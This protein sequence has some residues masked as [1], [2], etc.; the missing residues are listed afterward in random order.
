MTVLSAPPAPVPAFVGDLDLDRAELERFVR[1]GG[2]RPDTE[3][4]RAARAVFL[5]L[6][7]RAVYHLLTAGGTVRLRISPLVYGAAERFPGLVPTAA[8]IAA[9]RRLRQAEKAGSEI[10]QGIFLGAL[11]AVPDVGTHLLDTM[12]QPTH[13][14]RLLYEDFRHTGRAELDRVTLQRHGRVAHLTMSNP[15]CLNAEDDDLAE[16]METAVDLALLDEQTGVG[17]LRG[18]PVNH[19]K[20]RGRRIFSAGINL[21]DLHN[22]L[23]SFVDFL[24]RRELGYVSKLLRGLH[25]DEPTWA[26]PGAQPQKPWIA[27]VDAFAIGGG[28][29]LLL[30][31]DRVILAAD[32]YVSLPAAQEGIVPGA[33]NL[34][35]GRRVGGRLARQMIL[36]GRAVTA[37]DPEAAALCD[38]VAAPSDMDVA[39]AAAAQRLDS[40]A[41]VSNRRMLHLAEEPPDRFRE[42]LAAFA[43]EQAYRMY[44]RDVLEKVSRMSA[45]S[46]RDRSDHHDAANGRS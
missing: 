36:H 2:D 41:A 46:Q 18:A 10:D 44:D 43:V 4:H 32:A 23:I 38:E 20:H 13:R 27:A 1:H 33:A 5:R 42:Y 40:P 39:I 45:R 17:V 11:L 8:Q 34:R 3:R 28:A 35:L 21:I 14:A 30:T 26:P 9:E 7:A 12:R 15:R 24:M 31:C 29:Q 6:H 16:D 19:P 22:G 25:L 37:T